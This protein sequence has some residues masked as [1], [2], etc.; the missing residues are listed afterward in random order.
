MV[1]GTL[2][3]LIIAG[4]LIFLLIR[5]RRAHEPVNGETEAMEPQTEAEAVT[6]GETPPSPQ[7]TVPPPPSPETQYPQQQLPPEPE[8]VMEEQQVPIPGEDP[9]TEETNPFM[10]GPLDEPKSPDMEPSPEVIQ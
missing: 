4:I 3:P 10:D 9:M 6:D 7:D 8:P 2:I 1:L 5:S